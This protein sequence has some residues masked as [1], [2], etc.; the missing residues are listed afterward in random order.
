ML[1]RLRKRGQA[2]ETA[3]VVPELV[4]GA[5]GLG[6]SSPGLGNLA[7]GCLGIL[8]VECGHSSSGEIFQVARG[9]GD[10]QAWH[11]PPGQQSSA[12]GIGPLPRIDIRCGEARNLATPKSRTLT[13]SPDEVSLSVTSIRFSGF[14]SRCT[15]PL[16]W[17][18]ASA[19]AIWRAMRSAC[20]TS[21]RCG[22]GR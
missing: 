22:G 8:A 14:R 17:A 13:R 6:S 5:S 16:E 7:Q 4:L 10:A 18:A 12:D 2:V 20:G 9:L 11:D 21:I 19:E 1:R 3:P 15:T